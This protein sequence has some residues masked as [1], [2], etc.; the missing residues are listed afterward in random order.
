[1]NKYILNDEEL[2][3]GNVH[4][5]LVHQDDGNY[6]NGVLIVVVIAHKASTR[7]FH[8]KPKRFANFK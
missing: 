2:N 8:D 3:I 1:M 5:E 6:I 4:G 7:K